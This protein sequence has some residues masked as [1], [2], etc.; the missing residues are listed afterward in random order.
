M[1]VPSQAEAERIR[2][3]GGRVV[4]DANVNYYEVWGEYAPRPSRPPS[5]AATRSEMTRLADWVVADSELSPPESSAS[6]AERGSW[7]PDNVDTRLFRPPRRTA[8][9]G[10]HRGLVRDRSEGGTRCSTSVPRLPRRGRSSSLS[11]MR[12]RPSWRAS[13]AVPVRFEE[14]SLRRYAQVLQEA[15]VIV[16]PKRL[17]NGYELGRTEWR[18]HARDV[19]G[20]S[21]RSLEPAAVVR[22]AIEH[23]GGG[24]VADGDGVARRARA[25]ARPR[26]PRRPRSPGPGDGARALFEPSS[27][28]STP[29]C[30]GRSREPRCEGCGGCS[31]RPDVTSTASGRLP[32]AA[33]TNSSRRSARAAA[34]PAG[35]GRSLRAPHA[36]VP[37]PFVPRRRRRAARGPSGR[38]P[39]RPPSRGRSSSTAAA[40]TAP[41]ERSSRSTRRSRMRRSSSRSGASRRIAS[42]GSS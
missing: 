2:P 3:R 5:S 7:I 4:F 12:S 31:E 13:G 30:S 16:S 25:A 41:T 23:R 29:S 19:G 36:R 18:D 34:R 10:L 20:D 21:L 32:T 40:T 24:I 11:R 8:A 38:L 15:D 33:R 22:Q 27:R 37:A 26:A 17:V 28:V 35:L 39:R 9:T 42:S 6:T 1:D 14:F